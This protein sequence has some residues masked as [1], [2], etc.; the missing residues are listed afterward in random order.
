MCSVS[1]VSSSSYFI[2]PLVLSSGTC[3]KDGLEDDTGADLMQNGHIGGMLLARTVCRN[4]RLK[5]RLLWLPLGKRCRKKWEEGK[6]CF[7]FLCRT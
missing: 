3:V 6:Y 5:D 2:H 4:N 7:L 1:A